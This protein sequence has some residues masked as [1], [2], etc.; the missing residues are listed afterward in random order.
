MTANRND[1]V[2][3]IL[4]V[5]NSYTSRNDLPRL[6]AKLAATTEAPRRVVVESIVAG[7]ASLRRHWNA[8]I[9]QQALARA[10][11]DFVVLQEQSTLPLK[12]PKRYHENVRL[13]AA[14]IAKWPSR[15]VLYLTWARQQAPQ[16]QEAITAAVEAIGAEVGALVVPVGRAW[17]AAL[18]DDPGLDLYVQDGSHPSVAGSYL[19]ACTFIA[20][21]FDQR[22]SDTSVSDRSNIDRA[23]A[24]RLH[25][26]A[27]RF[28]RSAVPQDG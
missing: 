14:E 27:W 16:T 26:I 7:G 4:F 19:A 24:A 12:S 21:L 3:K 22:P 28:R 11:W 13:C 1:S 5:G 10:T 9:V 8:G 6:V 17:D 18:R 25:A 20:T 2:T 15:L 23:L